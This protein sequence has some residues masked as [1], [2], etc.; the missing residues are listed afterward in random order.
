MPRPKQTNNFRVTKEMHTN[1]IVLVSRTQ[2]DREPFIRD[3]QEAFFYG[4][5]QTFGLRDD[6]P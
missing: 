4:A 2:E 6:P 5:R 3:D 1:E